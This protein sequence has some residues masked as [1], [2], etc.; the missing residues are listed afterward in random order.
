MT[1]VQ[2]QEV[3]AQGLVLVTQA[4]E[5]V[6]RD[7]ASFHEAGLFLR[8]IASYMKKVGEVFDPIVEAAHRAHKVAL[9]QRTRMLEPAQAASRMVK[10]EMATFEQAERDRVAA[11]QRKAEAERG[12]LEDDER[13]RNATRLEQQG[14]PEA[15]AAALT[16]PVEVPVFTPPVQAAP[17]AEGISFRDSWSAEVTDLLALAR[18]VADGV[19]APT[20]LIP[21]QPALNKMAVALKGELRIPGVQ[22]RCERI[23][24][25]PA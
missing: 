25:V 22:P 23:S 8:T 7:T 1:T 18:A 11:E 21:N 6:V 5:I 24:A 9:E 3:E 15:A 10:G 17:R 16:A 13:L 2:T 14:K 12:R 4:E 20:L 19:V